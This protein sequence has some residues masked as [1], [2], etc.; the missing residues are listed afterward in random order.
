M[1]RVMTAPSVGRIKLPSLSVIPSF[2]IIVIIFVE[3]CLA[4]A[5][6]DCPRQPTKP[7]AT[8]RWLPQFGELNILHLG[9]TGVGKST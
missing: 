3:H 2:R 9:E 5:G 8:Y 7:R 4:S 1:K 6:M